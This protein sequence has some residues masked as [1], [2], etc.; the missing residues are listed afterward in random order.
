MC[1]RRKKKKRNRVEWGDK[2]NEESGHT[3][4]ERG[5]MVRNTREAYPTYMHI[6]TEAVQV[7]HLGL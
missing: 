2:R 4:D 3:Q 7:K 5:A 1:S 6:Y